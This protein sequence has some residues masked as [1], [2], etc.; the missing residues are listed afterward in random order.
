MLSPHEIA[1][2]MVLSYP[3]PC[4]GMDP[5]ALDTLVERRLARI[6]A[7]APVRRVRLTGEGQRVLHAMCGRWHA[8][9]T[10]AP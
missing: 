3:Q 4:P 10:A 8:L 9:R 5:E 6:E 7:L 2:L 1:T